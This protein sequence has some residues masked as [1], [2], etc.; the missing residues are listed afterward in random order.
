LV[1]VVAVLG[2]IHFWWAVKKDIAEPLIYALIFGVLFAARIAW[3][4]AGRGAVRRSSRGQD[5]LRGPA[6]AEVA[7]G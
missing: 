6:D 5:S 1:Y 3:A 4:T 2:V 7:E